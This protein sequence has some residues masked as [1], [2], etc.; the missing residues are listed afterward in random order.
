M[1]SPLRR[2]MSRPRGPEED[3]ALWSRFRGA[4]GDPVSPGNPTWLRVVSA[5]Q[6][7]LDWGQFAPIDPADDLRADALLKNIWRAGVERYELTDDAPRPWAIPGATLHFRDLI[8]RFD[9]LADLAGH[10]EAG[11]HRALELTD[12]WIEDHGTFDPFAWRAGPCAD[13]AW[14]W[15]RCAS[16]LFGQGEDRAER[17][18]LACFER[19]VAHLDALSDDSPDVQ[20]R[21]R[22]FCLLVC[23]AAMGDDRDRLHRALG[24]LDAECTTQI[25]PDGGHVSRSPERL[26]G[27]LC[28]LVAVRNTLAGCGIDVPDWLTRCLPRMAA[29]LAFFRAEDGA[30]HPFNDGSESRPERV[31][32]ALSAVETPPRRFSFSP[33][34]GYQKLSRGGVQV[35]LDVGEAP[36]LPFADFA[37]AGGLGIELSDGDARLVTSCGFHPA[38]Y[39]HFQAAAR[40]TA[41]HSTLVLAGRDSAAFDVNP[42]SRLLCPVGPNGIAAKRLEEADEVWLD[43]QHSGYRDS[44]GLLHR[45]RLF[46]SGDGRRVTGED[47]LSRPVARAPSEDRRPV[48]FEIRF[49]LHPTVRAYSEPKDNRFKLV[50]ERGPVWYFKTSERTRSE[51][52]IYLARGTAERPQCLLIS[53]WADPNGDGSGP[54]NCVRW[55]FLREDAS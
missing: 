39:L 43:A 18:R 2:P 8:H 23:L 5:G 21:L 41:A 19:Q 3:A 26:L 16:L 53:G 14:N 49:H 48:S 1:S 11:E 52:T 37:H 35:I 32:A 7:V 24:R 36:E 33:R 31:D 9:W 6:P 47:S 20:A 25:L 27:A 55:S 29:M 10:G 28:D 44:V 34:S 54:P 40:R 38:L 15:L 51:Q 30:L 45:R 4:L 42:A 17:E 22:S 50:S 46:M 13:R 12:R